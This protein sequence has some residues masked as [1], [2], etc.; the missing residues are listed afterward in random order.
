[1]ILTVSPPPRNTLK[2]LKSILQNN[3]NYCPWNVN[4]VNFNHIRPFPAIYAGVRDW[5]PTI[6]HDRADSVWTGQ[7]S[8]LFTPWRNRR[9]FCPRTRSSFHCDMKGQF[10][11]LI[12]L[13]IFTGWDRALSPL[14]TIGVRDQYPR[15]VAVT[16][17]SHC[18]IFVTW[19]LL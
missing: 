13:T 6:K 7:G 16:V 19:Q 14:L 9:M 11:E 2:I 3:F 8:L 12:Q 18:S 5:T 10:F 15:H 1:M 4:I 17:R